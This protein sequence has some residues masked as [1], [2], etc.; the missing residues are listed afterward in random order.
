MEI[1]YKRLQNEKGVPIVKIRSDHG[2]EFENARFKSFCEKNG[3]KKKKKLAPKSPRQNGVAERKNRVIQEMARVML[4]ALARRRWLNGSR[5]Q[6]WSAFL[7]ECLLGKRAPLLV[8][9]QEAK[10]LA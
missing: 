8:R 5:I 4:Q 9:A 7:P 10:K 6:A 2:K 1:L 3:I